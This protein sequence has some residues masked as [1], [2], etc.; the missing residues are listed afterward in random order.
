MNYG[1]FLAKALDGILISYKEHGSYQGDYVAILEKDHDW[2][3]YKGKFGSCSGCDWLE[4]QRLYSDEDYAKLEEA[5]YSEGEALEA[6]FEITEEAKKKFFGDGD[7]E[8]FLKIP[9]SQMPDTL[10]DFKALLPVNTRTIR[11]SEWNDVDCDAV[12]FDQMKQ[13]LDFDN[14]KYLEKKVEWESKRDKNRG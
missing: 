12:V 9:K 7:N 2:L 3:I 5:E 11:D 6:S 8:L 4:G 14:L 13:E 10:E 1:E